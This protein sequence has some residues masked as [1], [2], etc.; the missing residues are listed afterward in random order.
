[1]HIDN[2]QEMKGLSMSMI[3]CM[4]FEVNMWLSALVS[5]HYLEILGILVL[6]IPPKFT[7]TAIN[8]KQR[9]AAPARFLHHSAMNLKFNQHMLP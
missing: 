4:G 1:M 7:L 5:I 9:I 3:V 6:H 8:G 2:F